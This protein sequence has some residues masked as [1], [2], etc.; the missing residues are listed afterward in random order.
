MSRKEKAASKQLK[1]HK[2]SLAPVFNATY[3]LF[4]RFGLRQKQFS[5]WLDFAF[6]NYHQNAVWQV[7]VPVFAQLIFSVK[8]F[9]WEFQIGK[10]YFS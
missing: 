1:F 10:S 6:K 3:K 9:Y 5:K 8:L 4:S 7:F 2:A